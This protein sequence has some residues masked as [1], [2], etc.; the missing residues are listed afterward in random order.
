MLAHRDRS[1]ATRSAFPAL[2]LLVIA[3]NIAAAIRTVITEWD[4]L[5]RFLIGS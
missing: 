5:I 1:A 3:F 4:G 2:L